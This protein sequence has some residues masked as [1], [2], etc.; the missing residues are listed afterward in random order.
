LFYKELSVV[1]PITNEGHPIE[2]AKTAFGK[3]KK[4]IFQKKK[5]CC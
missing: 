2:I 1:D 4:E 3:K 5:I